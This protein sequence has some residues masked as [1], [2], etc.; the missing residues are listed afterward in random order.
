MVGRDFLKNPFDW[1]D[2]DRAVFGGGGEG[3]IRERRSE[4]ED[5]RHRCSILSQYADYANECERKLRQ[6][7]SE[8]DVAHEKLHQRW[9]LGHRRAL[10]K[11]VFSLFAGVAGGR[12]FRRTLDENVRNDGPVGDIIELAVRECVT[13]HSDV[14]A[15]A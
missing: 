5:M 3:G 6:T 11:P 7:L 1:V 4:G 14:V 9:H 12:A 15:A 8:V 10:L 13:V 2:T